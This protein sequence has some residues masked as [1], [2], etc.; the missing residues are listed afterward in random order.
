VGGCSRVDDVGC[1]DKWLRW[2]YLGSLCLIL[3]GEEREACDLFA[4]ANFEDPHDAVGRERARRS[5]GTHECIN[6]DGLHQFAEALGIGSAAKGRWPD[7]A[8]LQ[9]VTQMALEVP[10]G[11]CEEIEFVPL[12]AHAPCER[13]TNVRGRVIVRIGCRCTQTARNTL[14]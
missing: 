1:L 4:V 14:G 13:E 5:T 12:A 7:V 10:G 8:P 11:I 6:I 9:V 2:K 3:V